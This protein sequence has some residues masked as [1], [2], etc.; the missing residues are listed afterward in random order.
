M[1]DNQMYQHIL[2]AAYFVFLV[3]FTYVVLVRMESMPSWQ[4]L[5]VIAYICTFGCEKIRE[6]V[7]S[8]P[9]SIR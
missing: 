4:E 5:Y 6:I 2:Q 9:T 1:Y 7:S 8:E 3:L